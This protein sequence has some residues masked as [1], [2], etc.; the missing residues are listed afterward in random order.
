[1]DDVGRKS[2]R[3]CSE[4]LDFELDDSHASDWVKS[5]MVNIRVP[6]RRE[7]ERYRLTWYAGSSVFASCSFA[8]CDAYGT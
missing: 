7:A 4:E 2:V 5:L 3:C 8:L 1:M 6:M